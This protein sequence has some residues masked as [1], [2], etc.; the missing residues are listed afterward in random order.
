MPQKDPLYR[1]IAVDLRMKIESGEYTQ[2]SRLPTEIELMDHYEASRNTIRDAIRQLTSLSLVETRQGQGTFVTRK[3]ETFVTVLTGD[4]KVGEGGTSYLSQ[5]NAQ[6]RKA[7]PAT[8]RVEVQRAPKEITKRLRV[9]DDTQLVSRHEQRF[10][11]GIPWSLMTSF[12][13][14]EFITQGADRLLRAED[15]AEGA[16][17][18]LADAI[19]LRQV[20][21]REWITARNPDGN[22][23]AFFGITH[24]A[25]VFVNFRTAFDQNQKPMR[26]TV[27]VFTTDT[28]QFIVDV[29]DVP[30]PQYG[31]DSEPS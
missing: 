11:D 18:Y 25:T 16:V 30:D 2:G 20:G 21:Y 23:Q 4:P 26:V 27:T 9:P 19:G 7:S 6:H 12:Y 17:R 5:V 15:I 10:I 1:Q 28:N 22:E 13:P 8:P 31:E 3:G 24:E 14:M 29:G